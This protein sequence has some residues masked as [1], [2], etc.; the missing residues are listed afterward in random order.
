MGIQNIKGTG[1]DFVYRWQAWDRHAKLCAHMRA[2]QPDIAL[3]AVRTLASSAELG[4]LEYEHIASTIADTKDSP[5]TQNDEYQAHLRTL[6]QNRQSSYAN[7]LAPA[8]EKTQGRWQRAIVP[9]LE[10]LID[11]YDAIRR[12]RTANRIYQDLIDGRISSPKAVLLLQG[13]TQ[14]QKGGWL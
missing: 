11:G 6:E 10:R 3:E 5:I 2:R 12:R 9:K 4:I 14:R 13:L 1:L 7:V 8:E